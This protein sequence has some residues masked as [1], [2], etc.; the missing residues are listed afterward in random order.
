MESGA[1]IRDCFRVIDPSAGSISNLTGS[2]VHS[3]YSVTLHR[4]PQLRRRYGLEEQNQ[5]RS[6]ISHGLAQHRLRHLLRRD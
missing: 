6:R 3:L 1:R 4:V 2:I 5:S